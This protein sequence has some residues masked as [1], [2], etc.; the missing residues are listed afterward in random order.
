MIY[1]TI[2]RLNVEADTRVY[3]IGSLMV[4]NKFETDEL[5]QGAFAQTKQ[6]SRIIFK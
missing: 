1:R 3:G 6:G 2:G 5:D 4:A